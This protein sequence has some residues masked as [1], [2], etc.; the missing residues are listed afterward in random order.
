MSDP[1]RVVVTAAASGIGLAIAKDFAAQGDRVHICDISAEV[2]QRVID[3]DA[4]ITGTVCDVSNRSSVE[5]FIVD[6]VEKLGGIDVLVNNAGVSGPTVSVEQMDPDDWDAVIAV[7]L[8]GT[9]N[10]TRLAIPFLK[11]SDAGVILIMS[12]LGGRFGYPDRSPYATTKRGLIGFAETLAGELGDAGIRVNTIAP[13]AVA[14]ERLRRAL[15]GR[16]DA[17]GRSLDAVTADALSNQS[18]K[19]F[20]DP[21]EIGALCVFLAS[22]VAKSISGQTIPIDGDSKSAQ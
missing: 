11:Q 12:S 6:A 15:Q 4:L 1:R 18:I 16:A 9:F 13:G 17:G 3:D 5:A 7:N 22:D 19:R 2:L 21:A 8:T 14:G 10:V 20:V